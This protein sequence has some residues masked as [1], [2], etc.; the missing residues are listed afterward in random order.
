MASTVSRVWLPSYL[1]DNT[2]GIIDMLLNIISVIYK[3]NLRSRN[4][5]WILCTS[6][7]MKVLAQHIKGGGESEKKGDFCRVK[8]ATFANQ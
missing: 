6:S 1:T 2:R 8:F 4:Y 5:E 7:H 3:G